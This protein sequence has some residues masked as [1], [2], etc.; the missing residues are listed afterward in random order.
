MIQSIPPWLVVVA[1]LVAGIGAMIRL[2]LLMPSAKQRIRLSMVFLVL[3][4]ITLVIGLAKR[5]ALEHS[6]VIYFDVVAALLVSLVGAGPY[7]RSAA[8][9]QMET[10]SADPVPSRVSSRVVI[11]GLI[12]VGVLLGLE[13][14]FLWR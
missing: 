12:T 6:M 14:A 1:A 3:F 4:L 10:G 8:V 2:S 13:Y 7:I 5:Q 11:L 9:Q